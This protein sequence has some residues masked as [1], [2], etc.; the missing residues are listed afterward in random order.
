MITVSNVSLRYGD[1]KLFEDVNIKFAPGNCYGLIGANGAGK[2]TFIKIL[3]G[4]LEAQ[5][6]TVSLGPGERL[7]VLKQN[8]FEYE[9]FEVLKVVIMG[10]TRLYE[11]MQEKDA[12]YM[13]ADFT[14]EDGMRAAELEGEFAE[15]NG[16]EA[17]SEA[18]ILLKGLGISEDV[19]S[20]KWPN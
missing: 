8:H 3:A 15:L 7:A 2:S 5:S 4:E 6:G 17:E 11:I 19:H 1:R 12:I 16:W 13:K 14:D 20:K 18:A 10:H 9:D